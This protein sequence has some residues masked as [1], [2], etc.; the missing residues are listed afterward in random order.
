[1]LPASQRV[2][3]SQKVSPC[4]VQFHASFHSGSVLPDCT[5]LVARLQSNRGPA[6]MVRRI[7]SWQSG[8]TH[9][10]KHEFL[11]YLPP[12]SQIREKWKGSILRYLFIYIYTC[13]IVSFHNNPLRH[14]S[15]SLIH[16]EQISVQCCSGT[17]S[18]NIHSRNHPL[19]QRWCD[20]NKS[21][22]IQPGGFGAD[23]ECMAYTLHYAHLSAAIIQTFKKNI[24]IYIYAFAWNTLCIYIYVWNCGHICIHINIS[25]RY[26]G[27]N[28][29]FHK[30]GIN[31]L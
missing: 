29:M 24:Y 3:T 7:Q 27:E 4:H 28:D 14:I 13:N 5:Y 16:V 1:M 20:L 31:I 30:L 6:S 2:C 8:F 25:C 23:Q 12:T 9:I 18:T 10:Q 21:R 17:V 26:P 22:R 11:R 19:H 15:V